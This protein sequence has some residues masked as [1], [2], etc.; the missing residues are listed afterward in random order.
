VFVTNSGDASPD[1]GT[2]CLTILEAVKKCWLF[3]WEVS[4]G[5]APL[6][7]ATFTSLSYE[8]I[9]YPITATTYS[10]SPNTLGNA[11]NAL[12][13][14]SFTATC[15]F[16]QGLQNFLVVEIPETSSL[17]V[18]ELK[19]S[20]PT[21]FPDTLNLFIKGEEK[22]DCCTGMDDITPIV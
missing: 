1:L 16:Q 9:D 5:S 15:Y 17:A 2:S 19:I 3:K 7:D 10:A 12:N 14:P 6:N 18:P 4:T 21:G 11:I 8:G 22:V 13:N 20:N